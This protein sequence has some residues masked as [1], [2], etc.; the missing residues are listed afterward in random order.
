[1]PKSNGETSLLTVMFTDVVGSTEMR[2]RMGDAAAQAILDAHGDVVRRAVETNSG[3]V[4]KSLGDG[5]LAVFE[6]PRHALAAAVA[7]QRE[8]RPAG[9][10]AH[11]LEHG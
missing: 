6:S 8:P 2:T 11:R 4:V 10:R 9:G 3:R 5:Y 1:M 7:I